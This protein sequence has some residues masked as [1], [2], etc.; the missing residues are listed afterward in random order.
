MSHTDN[1][2]YNFSLENLAKLFRPKNALYSKV[3]EISVDDLCFVSYPCQ[4]QG[5]TYNDT[6]TDND[7][8][9][10]CLTG[11][12]SSPTL[13]PAMSPVNSINTNNFPG[14]VITMFNVIITSVSSKAM[15]QIIPDFEFKC[16]FKFASM[17]GSDPV[18]AA[19][20]LRCQTYGI[21]KQTMR[22][23]VSFLYSPSYYPILMVGFNSI[24][25]N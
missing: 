25:S 15:R 13:S 2:F 23:L 19:L 12:S 5:L 3:L 16:Q 20:G 1:I 22:R 6:G 14:E 24:N 9:S 21:C 4:C 17:P 18:A 7:S 10:N 11:L 8:T